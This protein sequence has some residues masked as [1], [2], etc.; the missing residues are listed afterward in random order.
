MK[1]LERRAML[2]LLL[3]IAM[4]LGLIYFVVKLEI[5]GGNWASFYANDHVFHK[6][7]LTVGSI[8]DRNGTLLLYYDDNGP[9]YKGEF[10]ERKALSTVLGDINYSISTAANVVFRPE[11]VRYNPIT[12]TEGFFGKKGGTV[13][14]SIDKK[15]NDA[16]YNAIGGRFGL[17]SVYNYRTGDI[18]CLVSTPTVDP[19]DAKAAKTAQDGAYINKV[20]S[21]KFT[22][23]STFKVLTALAAIENIPEMEKWIFECSGRLELEDGSVTCPAVHGKQDFYGVLSNS[24]NCA[25]A[26]LANNLGAKT[27]EDY[28]KKM[29]LVDSYNINGIKTLEGSFDFGG[30]EASLG[31]AGVGQDRDEINPLSMLV[32]MGAIA[33]DG[34]T[35]L[36]SIIKGGSSGSIRLLKESSARELKSMLR[37][38]VKRNYGDSNFPGLKLSAKSGT[39]QMGNKEIYNAWFFGFSGD[40]AFIVCV[41]NG[42]SGARVAGP[43][44]NKVMQALING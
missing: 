15:I 11:L 2:C 31:W 19:Q 6:G 28:T 41:E 8:E 34:E 35:A 13:K 4:V 36:P 44:A 32:F 12:G 24:C 40:Y 39:A 22:P 21:A 33:G 7:K 9:H 25:F 30:K 38:N 23:G 27:L 43:V 1:K 26:E 20:F 3:V 18:V 14:L 10:F 42:G 16:A 5:N 37:N 29:R 17:V